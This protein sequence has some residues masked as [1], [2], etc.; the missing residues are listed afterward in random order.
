MQEMNAGSR[1]QG[2]YQRT[3]S[4]LFKGVVHRSGKERTVRRKRE[5]KKE[6]LCL[7]EYSYTVHAS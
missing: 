4:T 6:S 1:I 7:A 5:R 2:N 3:L